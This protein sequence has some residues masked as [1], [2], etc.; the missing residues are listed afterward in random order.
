MKEIATIVCTAIITAT[1]C[2]A[3]EPATTPEELGKAV[4]TCLISND[5]QSVRTLYTQPDEFFQKEMTNSWRRIREEVEL[6]HIPWDRVEFKRVEM[7]KLATHGTSRV[8]DI[9]M[10][11]K[12]ADDEFR[13][14]LD[15]AHEKDGRWY[16][17]GFDWMGIIHIDRTTRGSSVP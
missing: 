9:V 1:M 7:K 2:V 11:F 17:L 5:L 16:V 10:V 6:R 14:M 3:G 4:A 8:A 12:V 13:I 15:E